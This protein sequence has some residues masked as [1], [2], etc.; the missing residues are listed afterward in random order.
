MSKIIRHVGKH[1]DKK[2]A[3]VF[4]EVPNETHMCLLVYTELLNRNIHDPLMQ[5]IESDLGQQSDSLADALNRSYTQDGRPILGILH[6][7][8]MLKKVRTELVVMTP[9]PGVQIKLNELNEILDKMAQ[10]EEAIREMQELDKQTGLQSPAAVAKHMSNLPKR[11]PG[12]PVPGIDVPLTPGSQASVQAPP[13]GNSASLGD[14]EIAN[15]LR[16]QAEKMARE[17]RGLLAESDR[18][19]REAAQLS[20]SPAVPETSMSVSPAVVTEA[21]KPKTRGRVKKAKVA[22]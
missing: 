5:C 16:Q 21:V 20:G 15:N 18:L 7:E 6:T 3:V 11:K 8:G 1:G 4:R 22:A 9:A 12:D 14:I 2:V 10:G 17:G 19:M 13:V